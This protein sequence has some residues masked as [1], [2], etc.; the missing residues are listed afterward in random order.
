M[1][2]RGETARRTRLSAVK[3]RRQRLRR[4]RRPAAAE[5]SQPGAQAAKALRR[6]GETGA[7]QP[8]GQALDGR[9]PGMQPRQPVGDRARRPATP[10]RLQK[11][12]HIAQDEVVIRSAL[13]A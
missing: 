12:A 7:P 11:R 6:V 9:G 4:S 3:R 1:R 8:G 13:I 10:A 2:A 5:Q